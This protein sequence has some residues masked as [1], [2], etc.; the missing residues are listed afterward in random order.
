MTQINVNYI[1]NRNDNGA[2]ELTHGA[3]IPSGKLI[4]GPGGITVAGVVTA[5]GGFVGDGSQLNSYSS[6]SKGYAI[7]L[8]IDPLP[9]RS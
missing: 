2:P 6:A 7:K 5:T 8:I 4:S 9:F 1:T 3:T